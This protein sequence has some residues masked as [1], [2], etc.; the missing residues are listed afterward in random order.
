VESREDRDVPK[1]VAGGGRTDVA[2][3]KEKEAAQELSRMQQRAP[4]TVLAWSLP[5]AVP[6]K[7]SFSARHSER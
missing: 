5:T 3:V 7:T 6:L 4:P 2:T 1:E